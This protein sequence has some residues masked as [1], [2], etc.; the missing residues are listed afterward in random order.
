MCSTVL[1]QAEPVNRVTL[2]IALNNNWV[3]LVLDGDD[4]SNLYRVQ[5]LLVDMTIK[6]W[7]IEVNDHVC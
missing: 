6:W 2:T 5:F 7:S 1:D 4:A 3:G